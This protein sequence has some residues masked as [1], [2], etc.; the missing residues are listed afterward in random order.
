MVDD[1]G[2]AGSEPVCL[3]QGDAGQLAPLALVL[4]SMDI[5]Y[6]IDAQR[7]ELLV[8]KVRSARAAQELHLYLD[9]NANWP[10][11][12][13]AVPPGGPVAP[14][15]LMLS[16]LVLLFGTTGPW[17]LHGEWFGRG[18]VDA[19]A[20][21]A[22]AQWWRL[23]TGMSLHADA[24]HLL[25]NVVLGGVLIHLLC[26][27]VGYGLAWA[28]LLCA[29]TL[30]NG[31]NVLLR[32]SPHHSV[33]FSTA[34]FA[35]IGLLAAMQMVRLRHQAWRQ[36]ALPLGAGA[37]LLALLG[38]EGEHTDLG[39]HLFGFLAGLLTGWPLG[40]PWISACRQASGLQALLFTLS[41]LVCVFAWWLA[42]R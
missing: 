29:G 33:G 27:A 4:E 28:M 32:Q 10:A 6:H 14:T 42:W 37:A 34:V 7:G 21:S 35:V 13:P 40:L 36:M 22:G 20:V 24:V 2:I 38:S 1:Q 19:A 8:A 26:G 23:I 15:L 18:M 41:A 3:A 11:V 30:G 17:S 12:R 39:A 5:D 31:M 16:A 25:G 9:E